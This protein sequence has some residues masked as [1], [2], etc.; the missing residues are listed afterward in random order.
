MPFFSLCKA[1]HFQ[2]NSST[3]TPL[4]PIM[5][6]KYQHSVLISFWP[7]DLTKNDVEVFQEFLKVHFSDCAMA[8]T[9]DPITRQPFLHGGGLCSKKVGDV[10]NVLHQRLGFGKDVTQKSYRQ[11]WVRASDNSRTVVTRG[12]APSSGALQVRLFTLD[13][14]KKARG[15]I[16]GWI[17]RTSFTNMEN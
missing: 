14:Y 17:R 1:F 11:D 6:T 10:A 13:L 5:P 16:T 9:V 7:N 3:H 4:R 15:K 2:V 12:R 8:K